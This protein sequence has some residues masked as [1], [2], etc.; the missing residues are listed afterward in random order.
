MTNDETMK[1][2]GA[3]KIFLLAMFVL[4]LLI[5][6]VIVSSRTSIKLSNPI[7]IEYIGISVEIPEGNGWTGEKKW[8]HNENTL[9]LRSTFDPDGRGQLAAVTCTYRLA[10]SRETAGQWLVD[11]NGELGTNIDKQGTINISQGEFKW[12]SIMYPQSGI[13]AIVGTVGLDDG[14][15]LVE[16]TLV[17]EQGTSGMRG[18]VGIPVFPE[19]QD[20]GP[21]VRY[22][23]DR[24]CSIYYSP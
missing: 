21:N 8:K 17:W 23:I 16:S 19:K 15:W 11:F 2:I 13:S 7:A 12:A 18:T 3:D 22:G 1:K 4:S 24:H 6:R 9:V 14:R 10:S 20:L 5:A